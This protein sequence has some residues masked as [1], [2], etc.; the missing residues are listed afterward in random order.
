VG[1]FTGTVAPTVHP[2]GSCPVDRASSVT[3]TAR[4]RLHRER[5]SLA[6]GPLPT[7]PSAVIPPGVLFLP[8]RPAR[9]ETRD[10]DVL[11][12]W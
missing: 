9:Q 4:F 3:W 2:G 7:T 12:V 1:T 10:F 6:L 5:H 8:D 11:L